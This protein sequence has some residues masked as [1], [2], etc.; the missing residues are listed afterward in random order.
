V[1]GRLAGGG[2]W[3][4]RL[5]RL[6]ASPPTVNLAAGNREVVMKVPIPVENAP[7]IDGARIGILKAKWCPEAV[8][9]MAKRCRALLLELGA[10]V[11][12]E[13]VVS[14][15]LELPTA[16]QA[17]IEARPELDGVICFG[18]ILKGDTLHFET[19]SH[20][21]TNRL[22]QLAIATRTP[23]INEVLSVFRVED[24]HER[25][26]DD[27][28]NKGLEAAVAAADVIAWRRRL[29]GSPG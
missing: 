21:V 11:P 16:A 20:E 15:S 7:R 8:E 6:L 28:Y 26:A 10:E 22:G 25:A 1:G 17:L 13:H 27:E 24:A 9:G 19:I 2:G 5:G 18:V 4:S 29:V 14:G 23:I 12:E 3:L